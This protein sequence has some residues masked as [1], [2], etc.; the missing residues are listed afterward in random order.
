MHASKRAAVGCC[1]LFLIGCV[2]KYVQPDESRESA[3]LTFVP[4]TGIR[5]SSAFTAY[6]NPECTDGANLGRLAT[7]SLIR[8][9]SQT[10]RVLAGKELFIKSIWVNGSGTS[11]QP[12]YAPS[13][14]LES[15]SLMNGFVPQPGSRYE[16]SVRAFN[17]RC[18]LYIINT[19]AQVVESSV[20]A[21]PFAESCKR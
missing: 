3:T 16:V 18:Q 20:R 11:C 7:L 12:S 17:Q 5:G 13:A 9:D 21:Y 8:A 1:A 2:A 15:C 19:D 6:A 4:G 14:C 10:T